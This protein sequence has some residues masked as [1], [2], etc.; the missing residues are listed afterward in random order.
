M[1]VARFAKCTTAATDPGKDNPSI[2]NAHI[3]RIRA[4]CDHGPGDLVAERSGR[5]KR[6]SH[7]QFHVIAKVKIP[8]MQMHIAMAHTT[9]SH[10]KHH[11]RA[12][13]LWQIAHNLRKR[14]AE[15][16]NLVANHRHTRLLLIKIKT[17]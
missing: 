15:A 12:L 6:A 14:S 10:L 1:L 9:A 2:A 11:L 8:V 16:F 5:L 3:A 4:D 7:I 13:G 17:I